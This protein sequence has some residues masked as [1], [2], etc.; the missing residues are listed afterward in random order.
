[1]TIEE[2]TQ[3]VNSYFE[4]K[5][6][7]HTLRKDNLVGAFI[8]EHKLPTE[9]KVNKQERYISET[10]DEEKYNKDT[11]TQADDDKEEYGKDDENDKL[12]QDDDNPTYQ[13]YKENN[14]IKEG[15]PASST[16]TGMVK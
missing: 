1:M 4:F 8:A 15:V 12:Y 7:Q 2:F 10:N 14:L 13:E 5:S 16:D 6:Y 9:R 11:T 3:K